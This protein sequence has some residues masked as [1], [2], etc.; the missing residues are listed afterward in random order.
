MD[1]IKDY[2][3]NKYKKMPVVYG[4]RT[5]KNCQGKV[6]I[7][8]R[9]FITVKDNILEAIVE[10]FNLRKESYNDTAFA[11]QK[12]VASNLKYASDTITQQCEE[13]WQFPFE[14]VAS[15]TGDCEDGAILMASLM[16]VA[17]IPNW[18]VKVAAG[19][20]Q[21]A[22]TAPQGGHAY[23]IY[24]ADRE[25]NSLEWEIHDWCYSQDTNIPTGKKPLAKNGGFN[26]RYKDVWFTFNDEFSWSDEICEIKE[27]RIVKESI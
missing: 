19:Y 13:F 21:T 4:G 2:W 25:N 1:C 6:N 8:V 10:K 11:C 15:G 14:T 9:N 17:G 16:I 12:Y 20:V 27:K 22:P 18:R 26:N 3:N 5:L 7:D 23:C 24:L